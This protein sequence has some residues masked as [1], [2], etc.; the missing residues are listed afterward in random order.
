MRDAKQ[1]K[2]ASQKRSSSRSLTRTRPRFVFDTNVIVSAFLVE[3]GKPATAV[4]LALTHGILLL[5]PEPGEELENVLSRS[6]FDRFLSKEAR[7][8]EL[9]AFV[10]DTLVVSPRETIEASRDPDDD[11]FLELAVA[12]KATCIISGDG[13]L[14]ELPPFEASR[15]SAHANF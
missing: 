5:S 1:R 10:E 9:A 13:D 15:S 8:K 11:K 12:G 4:D 2:T 7:L 14:L 3:D 6:K